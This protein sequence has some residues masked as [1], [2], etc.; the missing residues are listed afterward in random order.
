MKLFNHKRVTLTA[1]LKHRMTH[2]Y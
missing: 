1:A 2:H